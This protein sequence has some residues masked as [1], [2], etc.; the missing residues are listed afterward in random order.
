MRHHEL[1]EPT[2]LLEMRVAGQN[3]RRDAERLIGAQLGDDLF[4]ITDDR[5][6][7]TSA[8]ETNTGPEIFFD[9]ERSSRRKSDLP[10]LPLRVGATRGVD[11]RGANGGIDAT[12]QPVRGGPRF[13]LRLAH[14]DVA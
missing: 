3:E 9:D 11:E 5:E 4:G 2:T 6:S 12:D 8:R 7:D 1:A 13:R 14:D 10:A